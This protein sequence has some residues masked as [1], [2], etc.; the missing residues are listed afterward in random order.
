MP[1]KRLPAHLKRQVRERADGFCEY[2]Q[3]RDDI[4]SHT[5]H[6]DHV[7]PTSEGGEDRFD[8]LAHVCGGCN[9]SKYK[10]TH[11]IDPLTSQLV[12]LF[13]PRQQKW[14]AHFKWSNDLQQITGLTPVGRATVET[15]K[16]NR[17]ELMK[18]RAFLIRLS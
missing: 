1:K 9:G 3:S 6:G 13:N 11:A 2:C 17:K 7:T 5:F 12:P 14:T 4:A 10:K 16:L 18:R 15:L 8:N